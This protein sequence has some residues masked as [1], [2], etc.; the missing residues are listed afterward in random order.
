MPVYDL[1][2]RGPL[3]VGEAIGRERESVLDWLPSDSLF[4]ALVVAWGELGY[5]VPARLRSLS[6]GAPPW[7]L[8]SAFPRV[9]G[10]RF[11]PAPPVLRRA[12]LE[13]NRAKRIRWLSQQI[14]DQLRTGIQPEAGRNNWLHHG[15]VW[16]TAPERAGIPSDHLDEEGEPRLWRS[17]VVPRAAID[18]SSSVTHPFHAGRVSF[19]PGG[20]LWFA[21]RGPHTGWVSEAL[22]LLADSGLGGLRSSGHGAFALH[23]IDA[24]LPAPPPL[25]AGLCLSRF[26]PSGPDEIRATLQ[27]DGAAYRF[28][29]IGGWCTDDSGRPWRRRVVRMV[30]EGALVPN[31]L[32]AR[33]QLVDARPLGVPAFAERA[34]Y[35]FG[36]PFFIPAGQLAEEANE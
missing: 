6:E 17:S 7:V 29:S 9:A 12:G 1:T 19:A 27:Q 32:S 11:Y 18:R 34:V 25:A 31:A 22:E 28:V 35:R 2:L 33:G 21:V 24:D 10:I 26:A 20:G 4:A 36:L 30:A 16:I 3:H 8:S 15:A 13:G 14:L 23:E 5:D